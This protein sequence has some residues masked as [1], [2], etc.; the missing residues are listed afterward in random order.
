MGI[1]VFLLGALVFLLGNFWSLRKLTEH[2]S[3]QLS[4]LVFADDAE[5]AERMAKA[6]GQYCESVMCPQLEPCEELDSDQLV[7]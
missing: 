3:K 1:G 7:A 2:D 5:A 4:L 6:T